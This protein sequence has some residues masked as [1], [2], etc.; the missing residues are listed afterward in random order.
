VLGRKKIRSLFGRSY[1][2]TAY[3]DAESPPKA[4]EP[5]SQLLAKLREV[6]L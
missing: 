5:V 4:K 3:T 1:A 2:G 6:F